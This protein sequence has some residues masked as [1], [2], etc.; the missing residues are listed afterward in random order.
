MAEP[1][2]PKRRLRG[3]FGSRARDDA[4]EPAQPSAEDDEP[5]AQES[6]D[7]Q[8]QADESADQ[9][10]RDDSGEDINISHT[11]APSI[12]P[13]TTIRKESPEKRLARHEQSDTDAMGLDKRREVIG[14]RYSPTVVRQATAYGAVLAVI[15]A[16]V[17]GFILLAGKLDA[18]PDKYPDKAPWSKTDASQHKPTPLQ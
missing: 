17:V 5:Q 4:P 6:G 16:I 8:P 3:R 14:G 13:G 1:D 15:A 9:Q 2:K 7:E 12:G 18:P 10:P 11:T